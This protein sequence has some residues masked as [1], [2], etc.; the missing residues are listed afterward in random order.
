[1]LDIASYGRQGPGRRMHLTGGEIEI[2]RRTLNRDPEVVV[3]VLSQGAQDVKGIG[4]HL[5]YIGRDGDVPLL[6]DD[7]REIHERQDAT[8]LLTD[9]G[10]DIEELSRGSKLAA[11]ELTFSMPSGTPPDKVFGAVQ[12]FAREEFGL[13]HR[14]AMA[15]HT[16]E[17]HPHVHVVVKAMSEQGVRLNIKKATLR[18]WRSEF[19][20]HLR[21]QGV[22]ANATERLVRGRVGRTQPDGVYRASD[23]GALRRSEHAPAEALV[24]QKALNEIRAGW[25]VAHHLME[26]IARPS[27]QR[28]TRVQNF[29]LE[30]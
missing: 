10:L 2:I 11:T 17:P 1:M 18:M 9:W 20:R 27:W 19:A 25:E 13:A 23:R 24:I 26:H 21:E 28:E 12:N 30:R 6:T 5:E 22:R 14:Y 8:E 16:D 15:L 3:K 4:K 7:G 29:D